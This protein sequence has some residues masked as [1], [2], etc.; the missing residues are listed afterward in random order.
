MHASWRTESHITPASLVSAYAS[1]EIACVF[2]GAEEEETEVEL[3]KMVFVSQ[4]LFN[5]LFLTKEDHFAEF[6][7]A[8]P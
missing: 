8:C 4:R 6:W 2:K 3:G 1:I 7:N 5:G